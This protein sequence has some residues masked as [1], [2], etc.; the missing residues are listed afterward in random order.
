VE[1]V[2]RAVLLASELTGETAIFGAKSAF[3]VAGIAAQK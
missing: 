1:F 2:T 3:T